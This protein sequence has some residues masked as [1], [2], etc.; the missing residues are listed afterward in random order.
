MADGAPIELWW[1]PAQDTSSLGVDA[2]AILE[3]LLS[4]PNVKV[5]FVME[6]HIQ[7]EKKSLVPSGILLHLAKTYSFP[8]KGVLCKF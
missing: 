8:E 3:K 4:I 7:D 2:L 6:E 1:Q 5:V